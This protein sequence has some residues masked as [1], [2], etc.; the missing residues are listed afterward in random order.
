MLVPKRNRQPGYLFEIV[1][2]LNCFGFEITQ[3][4]SSFQSYQKETNSQDVD[5]VEIR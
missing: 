1:G 4:D 5:D 2:I 3:T